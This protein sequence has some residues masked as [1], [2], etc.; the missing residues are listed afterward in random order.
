AWGDVGRH[1]SGVP[2]EKAVDREAVG[3][4]NPPRRSWL[5]AVFEVDIASRQV[6]RDLDEP[7]ADQVALQLGRAIERAESAE[8]PL[9][10]VG[11]AA[12]RKADAQRQ[13]KVLP[14]RS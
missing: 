10:G 14:T 1:V 4:R 13:V 2:A 7:H 8:V 12:E 6:S 5:C 3:K 11:S 9:A